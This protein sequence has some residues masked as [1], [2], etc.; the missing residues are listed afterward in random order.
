M[1]VN[2]K[3]KIKQK[4]HLF[5]ASWWWHTPLIPTLWRQADLWDWG[6]PGL[7]SEF[8]DGQ[9]YT[10]KPCLEKEKQNKQPKKKKNQTKNTAPPNPKQTNKKQNPKQT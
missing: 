7:Q 6:H 2:L 8:Q 9:G 1:Y 10:E 5:S 4:T 3:N